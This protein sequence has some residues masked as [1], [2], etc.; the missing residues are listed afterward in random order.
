M[1]ILGVELQFD[2]FDADEL[3]VYERENQ[4]VAEKIKEPTQYEG[5]T[6]A[7]ALKIQCGIVNDFFDAVFGEG[8]AE[9]IFKGKNNI[10]DHM[11]AFA[12]VA[13]E[14]MSCRDEFDAMTN[15]YSP[16]RAERRQ[17]DK[18]NFSNFQRNANHGSGKKRN[19]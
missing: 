2:F 6:T 4:K 11:E 15:K 16:N 9:K 17:M 12:I 3:D 19:K 5:K 1:N 8:T 18:Q 14:A 7:E 10:K 13:N